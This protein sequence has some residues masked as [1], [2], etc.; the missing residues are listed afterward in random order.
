MPKS[1]PCGT[2]RLSQ[3]FLQAEVARSVTNQVPNASSAGWEDKA[4]AISESICDVLGRSH[5]ER[6]DEGSIGLDALLLARF[7]A[8]GG[9]EEVAR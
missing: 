4:D 9:Q 1:S 7:L 2:R 8:D 6:A 5:A 3:A